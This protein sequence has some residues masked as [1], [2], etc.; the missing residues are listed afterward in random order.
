MRIG[1][2]LEKIDSGAVIN[3]GHSNC[4]IVPFLNGKPQMQGMTRVDVGGENLIDCFGKMALDSQRAES[5]H[6]AN[7]L[8]Q[9]FVE[10]GKMGGWRGDGVAR[11]AVS[12]DGIGIDAIRRR[13]ESVERLFERRIFKNENLTVYASVRRQRAGFKGRCRESEEQF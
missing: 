3:L 1:W 12:R 7:F 2:A 4:S 5:V 8:N 11:A 6:K 10:T 13:D 9:M